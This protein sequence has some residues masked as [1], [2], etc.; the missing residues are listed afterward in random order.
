L[1]REFF[2]GDLQA[3]GA[4]ED[5]IKPLIRKREPA[6]VV[7]GPSL[8]KPCELK[9]NVERIAACTSHTPLLLVTLDGSEELAVAALRAGIRD[10]LQYPWRAQDLAD[11]LD[12]C[13]NASTAYPTVFPPAVKAC[14]PAQM[15]GESPPMQRVREYL[16]RAARTDST[17]LITGE[18]GTGK[19]LAAE[20]VHRESHRRNQPFVTIN[21]AAIPDSLLESELF[22]YEQGAFT[23]ALSAQAG[24]LKA[25]NGGTV[26][27]DEIGDMS[28]FAQAKIL[29]AIDAK[30]VQTLGR[31]AATPV[32]VR[33]V[34]ATNRELEILV[35]EDKFRRDLYYRL[36][37]ARVHIPPL[38]ERREDIPLIVSHYLQCLN[39]RHGRQV[40]GLTLPVWDWIMN[41]EWSGNV[42]ELKNL[43]EAGFLGGSSPEISSDQLPVWLNQRAPRSAHVSLDEQE[44]LISALLATDWNKSKAAEKLHWSR[45]TLYRKIAKYGVSR[46]SADS[47]AVTSVAE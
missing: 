8:A 41:Y 40:S 22:G 3:I 1:E 32:N 47:A 13:L 24:K 44:Q 14:S 7:L 39:Q 38:R 6:L 36:N 10:Y 35:T 4:A 33:I 26:F 19:E 34:A 37:V 16:A 30:E 27:L 11:V 9:A 12:R 15:I 20:F 18:T 31:S 28:L 42:R 46:E 45:M 25:A 23:G 2:K 21:C 43:L 17:I 29:R 5:E